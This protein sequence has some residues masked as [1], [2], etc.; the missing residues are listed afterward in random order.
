VRARPAAAESA[1]PLEQIGEAEQRSAE[2]RDPLLRIDRHLK[3]DHRERLAQDVRLGLGGR[4]KRLPPKY[5]Y[6]DR[7]SRLFDAICDLPE[8]YPTRT[9]Y[10]LLRRVAEPILAR[11]RPSHLVELGSGASRKTRVLLDA[12]TA[13][14]PGATYVPLDVSESMLRHSAASLR[15]RYDALRIHGIVGDYERHLRHIPS[16]SRRMVAFL[17]STIGNLPPREAAGF[18]RSVA[19]SLQRGEHLLLGLDLVKPVAVLEAAYNDSQGVTAAFNRNVLAVIN[20][21]LAA[22]F[23]LAE[24]E[25]VAFFNGEEEQVEMHLRAR[26]AHRVF[27]AA[28]DM[29]VDFEAGETIHTEISRKFRHE[30]ARAM[31]DASGFRLLAWYTSPDEYFAMALASVE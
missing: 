14:R 1:P 21:E 16:G 4:P 7:G 19:E 27:V 12:L 26:R 15:R 17:G 11:T 20:R 18:L 13:L 22:D 3:D 23:N 8:Y 9:E 10:V 6:D 29:R 5:F 25:H 2:A 30:T 28:L 24:F 31:L